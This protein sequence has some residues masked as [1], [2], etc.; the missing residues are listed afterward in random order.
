MNLDAVPTSPEALGLTLK[1]A[2]DLR[3]ADVT[4][5][6]KKPT[7][8]YRRAVGA[9]LCDLL[10]NKLECL[11]GWGYR[12]MRS[13]DFSGQT[14]GYTTTAQIILSMEAMGL[15]EHV[16]GHQQRGAD[17]TVAWSMASRFRGSDQLFDL[18]ASLRIRPDNWEDHF[19]IPTVKP[20]DAQLPCS[21]VLRGTKATYAGKKGRAPS[22]P[23]DL[24]D[25]RTKA[26]VDRIDRLNAFIS[27]HKI[28]PLGHVTFRRMFLL[29]D[30]PS[31]SWNKGGRLNSLGADNYQMAKKE[32]RR[33]LMIDGEPT[34]E[35]DI[36]ACNLTIFYGLYGKT[37][38]TR[39]DIYEVEGIPREVV[40]KWIN[41]TLG[42]VRF[43]RSW[44]LSIAMELGYET[45]A[46]LQSVYPIK[47]VRAK[48]IQ[49]LPL[50]SSWPN[51]RYGWPDLQ[52][53][54]SCVILRTMETLAYEHGVVCLPVHDSVIVPRSKET[55]AREVL[56]ESFKAEVGILP[57]LK[58]ER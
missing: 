48:V 15:L 58:S 37:L 51:S 38:P 53:K 7:A 25:P 2:E 24:N 31:F 8:P 4:E 49:S 30:D 20:A 40:K 6:H 13:N 11:G 45:V 46:K 10:R 47:M 5:P 12:S 14:V 32:K 34:T 23:L 52:Y 44:P 42:H 29:G 26:E 18:C 54:E 50:L 36:H 1:L 22:L 35:I 17:G 57:R 16:R 19:D 21:V 33:E 39:D 28:E 9:I 56:E 27:S 55:L 3:S 41:M 43:H